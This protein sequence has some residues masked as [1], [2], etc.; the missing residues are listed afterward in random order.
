MG[1]LKLCQIG[2][3]INGC[4]MAEFVDFDEEETIG[5]AYMPYN[6]NIYDVNWDTYEAELTP[7]SFSSGIEMQ[8][9]V[10]PAYIKLAGESNWLE[11][12]RIGQY[13]FNKVSMLKSIKIPE[14]V[15]TIG[16]GAFLNCSNL[17]TVNIPQGLT[18]IGGRAFEGTKLKGTIEIPENCQY[19]SEHAFS[20]FNS[21]EEVI[22]RLKGN[23]II[24]M[25]SNACDVDKIYLEKYE[26]IPEDWHEEWMGWASKIYN[27][28]SVL[29]YSWDS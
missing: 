4:G 23:A 26:S 3:L 20:N 13:S 17:E 11:V 7:V 15:E 28:N 6:P 16:Y 24:Q 8:N 12:K 21:T 22:I 19:I 2:C 5:N 10:I 18:E 14:T 27:K 9:L 1:E 29:I 25:E